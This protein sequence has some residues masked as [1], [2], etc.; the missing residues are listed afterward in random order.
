MVNPV[1]PTTTPASPTTTPAAPNGAGTQYT[2]ALDY[3]YNPYMYG[4][5]G[6]YGGYG[7]MSG[8]GGYGMPQGYGAK[9]N[10]GYGGYNSGYG[11][12]GTYGQQTGPMSGPGGGANNLFA[13]LMQILGGGQGMTQK[14]PVEQ[15]WYARQMSG[16]NSTIADLQ[17]QLADATKT[18]T[19]T[20][21]ATNATGAAGSASNPNNDLLNKI[22]QSDFGRAYNPATDSYWAN[23][24][25]SDS[26]L[27]SDPNKLAQTIA[28]GA[29][30]GSSD[31]NYYNNAMTPNPVTVDGKTY[32]PVI[33]QGVGP[34]YVAN[35]NA[36]NSN[37][38]IASALAGAVNAHIPGFDVVKTGGRIT[39]N[40]KTN[41][42]HYHNGKWHHD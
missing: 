38:A 35:L 8:Y 17:Q 18:S 26:S 34:G 25:A 9:G 39:A 14:N 28:G 13:Q 7:V 6:G 11:G 29:A 15:L 41:P 24:L 42:V 30:S 20:A 33:P 32:D 10:P 1:T 5:Q 19:T 16:L 36:A 12:Y 31:A 2:G 4:N 21:G 23:K 37:P 40:P 3:G 22:Y 27:A